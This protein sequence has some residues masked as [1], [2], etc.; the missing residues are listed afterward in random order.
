MIYLSPI[1]SSLF[2]GLFCLL[3]LGIGLFRYRQ[4]KQQGMGG[5]ISPAKS[6]WLGFALTVYY[7]WVPL[8]AWDVYSPALIRGAFSLLFGL[9]LFR[10][11]FQ[12]WRMYRSRNW[13][14]WHGIGLN[15][16]GLLLLLLSMVWIGWKEPAA[17]QI[18]LGYYLALLLAGTC[19]L[20]DSYYA[21]QFNRLVQ[22]QTTGKE[23]I[24]FAPAD[25]AKFAG[26]NRLTFYW[27]W[28]LSIFF[29]ALL[30]TVHVL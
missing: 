23:G 26:I 19:L 17:L 1:P 10:A 30:S 21:F 2:G 11:I 9:F 12:S 4:N 29:V 3:V 28:G 24:W 7:L 18:G 15:L 14:P 13:T 27:N 8:L 5:A 20:L 16:L 6:Y 22:G 25:A